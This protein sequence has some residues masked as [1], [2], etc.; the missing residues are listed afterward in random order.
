M[1][2]RNP[3]PGYPVSD[4]NH[5]GPRAR[6]VA[7]LRTAVL[8]VERITGRPPDRA[9][10]AQR[11]NIS[12]ASVYA[13]LNGTTLPRGPMF[14]ELLA[15]LGITGTA[16]GRLATLRDDAELARLRHRSEGGRPSAGSTAIGQPRQLPA[17]TRHFVGRNTEILDLNALL[18]DQR[19]R[20]TAPSVLI[21]AIDG[22][23]GVGKTTLALNWAHRI[24][25]RFP[26]GQ[27]YV[28]LQGFDARTPLAPNEVLH[29][30]LRALGVPPQSL[31]V[32]EENSAALYRSM[33]ADRR[34]LV[35]L[36][37]AR[38]AEQ[39]RPL[40]PGG[41]GCFVLVTSR[42]RLTSL[43]VR[44]GAAPMT[45][46]LFSVEEG[47]RLLSRHVGVD[48]VE[49]EPA[50][51]AE[52][53]R[54]CA[55]LPLALSVVGARHVPAIGVLVG[56]LRGANRRLDLLEAGDPD[57]NMR[58]IFDWSFAALPTKAARLFRQLSVHPGPN[59]DVYACGALLGATSPPEHV[60]MALANAN[61][62]KQVR[63]G[64]FGF[65]DL[66]RVYA[67]ELAEQDSPLERRQTLERLLDFYLA[68][69]SR[70]NARIQHT[71]PASDTC[72]RPRWSL[73]ELSG[74]QAAMDWF[75]D[76]IDVIKILLDRAVEHGLLTYVWPLAWV[77]TVFLHRSGRH[78]EQ[79]AIHEI[80]QEVASRAGDRPAHATTLRRLADALA[81]IGPGEE[82]IS[83]L[84][85]SL[86]ECETVAADGI[87][88][89]RLSLVRV[90]Q[91]TGQYTAALGHAERAL[92]R[93][94]NGDDD[95]TLADG[96][97]SVARQRS[98]LGQH[99]DSL[100]LP[101]MA[102]ERC[103]S[104]HHLEGQADTLKIV[105]S[106]ACEP[107]GD[108]RPI[109]TYKRV[110]A[111]DRSLDNWF[112]TADALVKLAEAREAIGQRELARQHRLEAFDILATLHHPDAE[113]IDVDRI[114]PTPAN[115]PD[116]LRETG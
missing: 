53:V 18:N 21:S 96:L 63:P 14:D 13:Y 31:P 40:L 79:V 11:L 9:A 114:E 54:L 78:A 5:F 25:D 41:P 77:C 7:E 64:R 100:V 22:T 104:L 69:A 115:S 24:A 106:V 108:E 60:V 99:A 109:T 44:E 97:T 26:D 61:L 16:A 62:I 75:T 49:A 55:G 23:A 102:V 30:F 76:E 116:R 52:L 37:N 51:A 19:T 67:T 46:D 12:S 39:V 88:Q 95:L 35:V 73:P 111:I 89:A 10:L 90:L 93:P 68:A 74:Y 36:D 34:V 50:T 4:G 6:F 72:D 2:R 71:E 56:G 42:V 112:W 84:D 20:R 66:L 80:A 65:H 86:A 59:V 3:Q 113:L 82:S 8:N 47:M 58:T 81:R 15:A 1:V 98:Q 43:V 83:L 38:S 110:L 33:L 28:N 45:L 17:A 85:T 107:G 48:L 27:L 57:I 87:R 91:S 105:G 92:R 32:D 103:G 101:S 70:A 94:R 29:R